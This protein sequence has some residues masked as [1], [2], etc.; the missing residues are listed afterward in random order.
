MYVYSSRVD[1]SW[2]K[3]NK[4]LFA[5]TFSAQFV[6]LEGQMEK[7]Y[8]II[9]LM[10]SNFPSIPPSFLFLTD[11]SVGILPSPPSFLRLIQEV[12]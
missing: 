12:L 8:F 4:N 1:T 11:K 5:V 7:S 9:I 2:I 10:R 3:K 6:A